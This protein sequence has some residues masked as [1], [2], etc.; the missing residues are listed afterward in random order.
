MPAWYKQEKLEKFNRHWIHRLGLEALKLQHL[1][2]YGKRP[3]TQQRA[4]MEYEANQYVNS[5]Y[6][7]EHETKMADVYVTDHV[8]VE[9]K[10]NTNNEGEDMD[11]FEYS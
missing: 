10:V 7:Y 4:Q 11:L 6:D 9:K 2:R 1:V 5:C 8:R 3:N